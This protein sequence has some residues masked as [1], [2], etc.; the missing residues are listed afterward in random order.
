M[1]LYCNK[2]KSYIV[3][4]LKVS[5]INLF[6]PDFNALFVYIYMYAYAA[7]WLCIIR[8]AC[9]NTVNYVHGF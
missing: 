5:E 4:L 2:K 7:W 3:F 1:Y 6:A 8:Y 9:I